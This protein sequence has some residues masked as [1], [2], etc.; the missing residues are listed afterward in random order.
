MIPANLQIGVH[1]YTVKQVE[2]SDLLDAGVGACVDTASHTISVPAH[3]PDS[4]KVELVFHEL[5]HVWLEGHDLAGV[6]ELV[7]VVLGQALS[8]FIKDNQPFLAA[9]K[10]ALRRS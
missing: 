5:V 8:Q 6:E 7:A 3:I 2:K 9:A 4:R 10:K 1:S